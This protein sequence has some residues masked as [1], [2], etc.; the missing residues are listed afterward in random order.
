MASVYPE[1]PRSGRDGQRFSAY[2]P[3]G[4]NDVLF[5]FTVNTAIRL[6]G[7]LIAL[8]DYELLKLAVCTKI[9]G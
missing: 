6:I 2:F 7:V 8:L 9:S 1:Y 3:H 5:Q 4:V